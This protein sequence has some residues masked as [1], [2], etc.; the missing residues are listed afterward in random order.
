MW[1]YNGRDF[2]LNAG[3]GPSWAPGLDPPCREAIARSLD[4]RLVT[5][6]GSPRAGWDGPG[7][8]KKTIT[9]EREPRGDHSIDVLGNCATGTYPT[10]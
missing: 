6:T 5:V 3:G 1:S 8:P 10:R 7:R 4:V 2:A 9:P